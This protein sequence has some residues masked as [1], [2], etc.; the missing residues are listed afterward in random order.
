MAS[1]YKSV[2]SIYGE[3]S[4][5]CMY[6]AVLLLLWS[7]EACVLNVVDVGAVSWGMYSALDP[8]RLVRKRVPEPPGPP[9]PAIPES[10][11]TLIFLADNYES[12]NAIERSAVSR[13]DKAKQH[14][15]GDLQL[16]TKTIR[17]GKE[18]RVGVGPLCRKN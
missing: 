11:S 17:D 7:N 18:H 16:I 1:T 2:G 12:V 6:E 14:A 5:A 15:L 8:R 13:G 10:F 9:G 3:L 4:A